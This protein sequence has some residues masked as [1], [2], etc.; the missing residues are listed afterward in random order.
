MVTFY[1]TQDARHQAFWILETDTDTQQDKQRDIERERKKWFKFKAKKNV[2]INKVVALHLLS[3]HCRGRLFSL[4]SFDEQRYLL[5]GR[6][7][8][9]G[10]VG[11][12]K[13]SKKIALM[14]CCF[15][16]GTFKIMK[17][18]KIAKSMIPNERTPVAFTKSS[19]NVGF[20]HERI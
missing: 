16:R 19:R 12:E 20:G 5:S 1:K 15:K 18:S 9:C 6:D 14:M 10:L 11:E 4:L 3:S 2:I 7:G 13:R 17:N 8:E